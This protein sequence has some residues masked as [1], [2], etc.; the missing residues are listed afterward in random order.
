MF[1]HLQRVCA[2]QPERR[3]QPASCLALGEGA[4]RDQSSYCW[5]R[6]PVADGKGFNGTSTS[7]GAG[8]CEYRLA[9]LLGKTGDLTPSPRSG[10]SPIGPQTNSV[11]FQCHDLPPPPSPRRSAPRRESGGGLFRGVFHNQTDYWSI[12]HRSKAQTSELWLSDLTSPDQ[13]LPHVLREQVRD[14]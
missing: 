10:T 12:M 5:R 14:S 1:S 9:A 3:L 4:R 8:Q 6:G 11:L 7:T 2:S 13:R